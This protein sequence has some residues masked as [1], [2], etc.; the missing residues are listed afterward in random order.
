MLR[1]CLKNSSYESQ[2]VLS[3]S[4]CQFRLAPVFGRQPAHGGRID[5]GRVAEN[6]VERSGQPDEEIRRRQPDA[7]LQAMAG[8]ILLR[9]LEGSRRDVRG[10]NA[11]L[12]PGSRR[13]HGKAARSRA[14]VE[15]PTWR[16]HPFQ[17]EGDVR[18]RYDDALVDMERHSGK[19]SFVQQVGGGDTLLDSLK[20]QLFNR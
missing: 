8:D 14:E 12:G 9:H 3:S 15:H 19:P 18:A 4:Q 13:Q 10:H 16:W 11:R 20:D 6:Q 7:T 2:P 5:V 17:Q 1:R